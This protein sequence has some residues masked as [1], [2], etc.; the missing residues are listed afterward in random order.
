MAAAEVAK[1]SDLAGRPV[2]VIG[3]GSWGTTIA[4]ILA[5]KGVETRLWARRPELAQ[6]IDESR[7]N[8]A[9][10]PSIHLPATLD[11]TSDMARAAHGAGLLV[12]AV[13][14]HAFRE[15]LFA[16]VECLGEGGGG[17]GAISLVSLT[18]GLEKTSLKRMTEVATELAPGIAHA[19]IG[20]LTGPNLAAE[21]AQG[22]PAA[23]LVAMPDLDSAEAVQEIFMAPSFRIYSGTDVIGAELGGITKNVIAIAAGVADGLGFGDNTRA[24][25]ITRGLAEAARL[26]VA[27]GADPLTFAGLAGMGD[28]IATCASPRS[29]NRSIGVRLARGET[30]EKITSEMRMVAEGVKSTEVVRDLAAAHGVEMPITAEV[31]AMLY[32]EKPPR[33][34]LASLLSRPIT[35]ELYGE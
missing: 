19:R 2:A 10:L 35:S 8:R 22:Q 24:T 17:G 5:G 27:L 18:K 1:L 14:S 21:I 29:R 4:A 15:V 26:G 34:A 3:A 32:E 23:S 7:E 12:M 28:L 11:V 31:A 6:A 30:I 20:V 16:V 33:G 13:P 25:L 9:Y